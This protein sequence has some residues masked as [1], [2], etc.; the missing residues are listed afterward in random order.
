MATTLILR[1]V[2]AVGGF[3]IATVAAPALFT[4]S[5]PAATSLQLDTKCPPGMTADPISGSCS[6]GSNDNAPAPVVAPP[7]TMGSIDGI[8]CTGRNSGECIGLGE[9]QAPQVQ[10][11]SSVGSSP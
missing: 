5:G 8:P 4:L 7:R 3:A 6:A 2:I 9:N 11:H 1:R 10:P